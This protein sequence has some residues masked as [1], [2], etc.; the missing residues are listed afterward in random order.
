MRLSPAEIDILKALSLGENLSLKSSHRLRLEM[1]GLVLDGPTGLS[2]TPA[3]LEASNAQSTFQY[4]TI[5]RPAVKYDT[6]GKRRMFSR[7]HALG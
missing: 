2:L 6:V 4:E 5:D 7:G 1:L 3:G